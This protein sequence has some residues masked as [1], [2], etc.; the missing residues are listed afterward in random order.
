MLQN[1]AAPNYVESSV[2]EHAVCDCVLTQ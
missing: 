1:W 2:H